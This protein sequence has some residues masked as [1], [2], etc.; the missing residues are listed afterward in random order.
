ME[1]FAKIAMAIVTDLV[2]SFIH[3]A[4]WAGHLPHSPKLFGHARSFSSLSSATQNTPSIKAKQPPMP[5]SA[6]QISMLSLSPKT[7]VFPNGDL[8]TLPDPRSRTVS[9]SGAESIRC[10]SPSPSA[11]PHPDL[12][13]EVATLST[14]LI[15]AINHQTALDDTLSATRHELEAA[16][17]HIRDLEDQVASQRDML[18]GDVWVRRS[19]LD[20]E[21]KSMANERKDWQTKLAEE[22][23]RRLDTEK[24]KRKIEQEL[25]NLTA[26]LFE[27]ANRMVI[28]AKEESIRQQELLTKKNDQ[29][30]S[31]LADS[32]SLLKSQQEQLSEL[33]Q[34]MEIMVTERDDQTNYTTP[35]SP[36]IFRFDPRD[37]VRSISETLASP[38]AHTNHHLPDSQALAPAPPTSFSHLIQPVLR[39]DLG[40]YEDF[41]VLIHLSRGR[42]VSRIS[43]GSG[44]GLGGSTSSAHPTN[45]STTSLSTFSPA[46]LRSAP[47][48][49]NTPA[50]VA[51]NGSVP[52][53]PALKDTR[54]YKRVITEDVEPTLRLDAAPGLSWLARRTVL[55]AVT[56]GSL[57]VEPVPATVRP[58]ISI[59]PQFY[60]CAMCG[61]GRREEPFLRK[62]R[63]RTSETD[64]AQRYPLCNYCVTRVR[65]TCQFLGF[66]RM[67]KDGYWRADDEDQ[68]K[69]AWEESVRLR[70]QMFWARI[71]GGVIP[72]VHAEAHS[73]LDRSRRSS[74]DQVTPQHNA[75]DKTASSLNVAHPPD[76][77]VSS[78]FELD[79]PSQIVEEPQTPP[80]KSADQKSLRFSVHSQTLDTPSIAE[81]EEPAATEASPAATS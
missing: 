61:E 43:A 15:N 20:N 78:I 4:G 35:S 2:D 31:Q 28:G 40:A 54:F 37:E 76:D 49:P 11:N 45:T 29:L 36:R 62:Y 38:A 46:P 57:V 10:P 63:F 80:E 60:P 44:P 21:R 81:S 66:L 68:E 79:P 39:T 59:K 77:A 72:I 55:S 50:S 67:V 16:R 41:V 71:G 70:E 73:E 25:E 56:D 47:Q 12:S 53:I 51:S 5:S 74:R 19:T 75:T 64:S 24:E 18:S 30:Q 69:A 7:A 1:S 26:A 42:P 17:E 32:E 34:V 65:S 22:T 23:A 48:S 58:N 52:L 3:V 14:K 6:S 9:A 27:E 33:K 13:D 8:S